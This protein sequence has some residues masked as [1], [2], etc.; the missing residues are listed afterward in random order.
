MVE[1]GR[2]VCW[3]DQKEETL[4]DESTNHLLND[5][6]T[7]SPLTESNLHFDVPPSSVLRQTQFTPAIVNEPV[8]STNLDETVVLQST[9]LDVTFDM[10]SAPTE[11]TFLNTKVNVNQQLYFHTIQIFF[12]S[13]FDS[14][15]F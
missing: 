3:A 9:G 13:F 15:R 4:K 8:A 11:S 14:Q 5:G 10:N 6:V 2:G 1:G 12:S 7:L